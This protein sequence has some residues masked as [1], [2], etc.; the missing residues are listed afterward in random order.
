MKRIINY[1]ILFVLVPVVLFLGYFLY[2]DSQF[3]IIS[4]I[5]ALLACVPFFIHFEKKRPD[6]RE[7]VLVAIFI[8]ISVVSRILFAPIPGFKPVAAFTII[9]AMVYGKEMGF[10]VGALSAVLSNM[11]FGHG[12]W[13]PFQ[14]FAWGIIGFFAGLFFSGKPTKRLWWVVLYGALSGVVFSLI[15]DI[16]T[17]LSV[18]DGF[19]FARYLGFVAASFPMMIIYV[20][21]N[22][23]FLLIL[24]KPL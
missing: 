11:Y 24:E 14:M 12:P 10:M 4:I 5:I 16:W 7:L 3:E 15:L 1:L 8:A 18:D 9:V 13:T 2:Q 21:S 23:L 17:T 22:C 20:I 6:A 19:V